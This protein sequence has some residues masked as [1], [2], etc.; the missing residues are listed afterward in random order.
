[1]V[2]DKAHGYGTYQH[3]EGS[4]YEGQWIDKQGGKGIELNI[5]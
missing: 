2:I 1:M 4:K 5:Y 3:T